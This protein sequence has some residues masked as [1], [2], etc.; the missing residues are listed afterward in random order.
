MNSICSLTDTYRATVGWG[1]CYICWYL[2]MIVTCWLLTADWFSTSWFGL[3]HWLQECGNGL[4]TNCFRITARCR[5]TW[6]QRRQWKR[7]SNVF[8][9]VLML[10]KALQPKHG[11][12]TASYAQRICFKVVQ[13]VSY[14]TLVVG[15]VE[16]KTHSL[17]ID[18]QKLKRTGDPQII[19]WTVF[20]FEKE[21]TNCWVTFSHLTSHLRKHKH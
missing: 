3:S 5:L 13:K 9:T 19:S 17:R 11:S 21:T 10:T 1:I 2:M 14:G 12:M 4:E 7:R 8:L 16:L 6:R 20:W 18:I 15:C